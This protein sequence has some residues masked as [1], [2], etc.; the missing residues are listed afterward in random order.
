MSLGTG[1]LKVGREPERIRYSKEVSLANLEREPPLHAA[2]NWHRNTERIQWKYS[3]TQKGRDGLGARIHKD[4]LT[5]QIQ[6][7]QFKNAS[8]RCNVSH[9]ITKRPLRSPHNSTRLRRRPLTTLARNFT[10]FKL[11][12]ATLC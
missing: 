6:K 5:R 7:D 8:V 1:A 10:L 12:L 3:P 9:K 11:Y 2:A 4:S